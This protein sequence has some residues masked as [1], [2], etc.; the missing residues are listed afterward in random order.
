MSVIN[1]KEIFKGYIMRINKIMMMPDWSSRVAFKSVRTDKNFV[2]QLK[3]GE[4]PIVEN[5]KQNIYAALNNMSTRTDRANIEFLLDVADNL[6]YG[7]G[8]V[9]SK[10]KEALDKDGFTPPERENTD[11]AFMLQDTIKKALSSSKGITDDKLIQNSLKAE[12]KR[13]FG[14]ERELTPLQQKLLQL[15][16][17][18]SSSVIG[19]NSIDDAQTLAQTARIRKNL[20]YFIAS[21]EISAK[22]KQECLEKFITFMSDDYKINPQLKDKKLQVLDEMLNDLIIKT[23]E[24]E[25]LTIK[26]VDQRQSGMCAALSICR[27]AIAYEDKSRYVDLITE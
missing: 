27:K 12:Y 8:G 25:V 9:N 5:N 21:S 17:E 14:T 15:R 24:S 1:I 4:M 7:Q 6:A 2:G 11:W 16:S 18:L 3:T 26:S 10:F 19:E 20:D 23:P 22:Q 13:I